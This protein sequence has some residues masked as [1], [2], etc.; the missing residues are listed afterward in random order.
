VFVAMKLLTREEKVGLLVVLALISLA[1]LTIRAGHL[2]LGRKKGTV[3]YVSFSNV[4]GLDEGAQVRVAGVEAGRVEEVSLVDGTPRLKLLI[5]PGIKIHKDAVASIESLGFMGEK[6]VELSP[7]TAGTPYF[8]SG[9]TIQP[10]KAGQD[11]EQVAEQIGLVAQEVKRVIEAIDETIASPE[12]KQAMKQTLANLE[13]ITAQLKTILEQNS[14]AV[15]AT[16]SNVQHLSATLDN[17]LVRN[18]AQISK[19]IDDLQKF[20]ELLRA[21]SPRLADRFQSVAQSLDDLIA[22]NRSSLHQTVVNANQ[23]VLKL[24]TA[25]DNVNSLLSTVNKG[26]GTIGKLIKDE[27]LYREAQGTLAGLKDTLAKADAFRLYLGY[28]GEYLTRPDKSKSYISLKLQPRQDKY[29]L[30]ELVDDFQGMTSTKETK[31]Y[32]DG[33]GPVTK[34]EEVCEERFKFSFQIAKRFEDVVLRGGL[35]ESTGGVGLDYLSY[36]DRVQLHLN[37]WDFTADKPHLK[38]DV[39]YHLGKYFSLNT[40]F[41]HLIDNERLSYFLGAGFSFEDEDLKYL[42]GKIPIPGL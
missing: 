23:L 33:N 32:I 41:D 38:L 29:Y 31:L 26:E 27:T 18:E 36:G 6:Y 1:Y 21:E 9:S 19:I 39:G 24:Q 4:R 35:I 20:A 16:V 42:L 13:A 11:F 10:G 25:T 17:I 7:G 40:G 2:S 15:K 14:H 8:E 22:E 34:R 28:R 12:G 3:L 37:A 5:F 30:L